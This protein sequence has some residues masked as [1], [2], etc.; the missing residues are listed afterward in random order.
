MSDSVLVALITSVP[1]IV[2]SILGMLVIQRLQARAQFKTSQ[3]ELVRAQ[4]DRQR[5]DTEDAA[6]DATS[7]EKLSAALSAMGLSYVD[8]VKRISDSVQADNAAVIVELHG[9]IKQLEEAQVDLQRQLVIKDGKLAESDRELTQL[10]AQL[11]QA[12][13]EIDSL[14]AR[15]AT[16]EHEMDQL[17]Q[18]L[19]EAQRQ[20]NLLKAASGAA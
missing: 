20:I 6:A 9:R 16:Q 1:T 15:N 2:A 10:G 5:A 7:V 13:G 17:R 4:A 14:T 11:Q 8:L 12:R 18:Q 19:A 3:A